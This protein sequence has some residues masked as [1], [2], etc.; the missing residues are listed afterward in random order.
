[1]YYPF[2][3]MLH[4]Q[5]Q[6]EAKKKGE[7]QLMRCVIQK[8]MWYSEVE[9]ATETYEGNNVKCGMSERINGVKCIVVTWMTD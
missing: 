3:H 8:H 4:Q 7:F 5:T 6:N 2:S 1:M 9:Q